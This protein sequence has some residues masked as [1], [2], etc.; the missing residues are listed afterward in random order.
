[1]RNTLGCL[2]KRFGWFQESFSWDFLEN[3]WA[4]F[5]KKLKVKGS[6]ETLLLKLQGDEGELV[7]WCWSW[8][9]AKHSYTGITWTNHLP[10]LWVNLGLWKNVHI[11]K[12]FWAVD[13]GFGVFRM[14]RNCFQ[15]VLVWLN[16]MR[17]IL[18]WLSKKFGWLQKTFSWDFFQKIGGAFLKIPKSEES[19]KIIASGAS[20]RWKRACR[21]MLE[22]TWCE[23]LLHRNHLDKSPTDP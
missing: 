9:G 16:T 19:I 10:T 12:C 14:I 23:A 8:H 22:L 17:N 4:A 7:E 3:F 15:A 11:R 13:L 1:M 2:S 6:L 5:W 20:R 21:V 18:E